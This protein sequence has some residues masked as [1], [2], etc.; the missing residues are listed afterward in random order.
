LRS[1]AIRILR[2]SI[3]SLAGPML[4]WTFI[5]S[6]AFLRP[7]LESPLDA[8]SAHDLHFG[9]VLARVRS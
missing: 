7:G 4:S 8:S 2:W 1:P 9:T 6:T 5:A 3:A